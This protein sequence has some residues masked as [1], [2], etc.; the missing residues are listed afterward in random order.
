MSTLDQPRNNIQVSAEYLTFKAW[1]HE[2]L[3]ERTDELG[4][5]FAVMSKPAVRR[6][7]A[8][9][10][11]RLI[12]EIRIPLN[13]KEV[14]QLIDDLT[15]ELTGFGP[16]EGPLR[17]P[18]V[19]DIL[20]NGPYNIFI[21]K[22]GVIEPSDLV[23]IDEWHLMR[24]IYRLL[25]PTGRRVDESSPMVDARL[26][27]YGRINVVIPPLA[28]DGP[29][30]SIR[31]FPAD[32]L[33]AKDL[34]DHGT[35]TPEML[36][37]LQAAVQNRCNILISG[38]TSSGKTTLLNILASFARPQE[39]IVTIEDT[40]ELNLQARHIVRLET[41]PGGHDGAGAIDARDLLRNALR[42]RPDRIIVGEVRGSEAMEMLQ[43]MTTGHD[44][45]MGTLH[46]NSPREALQ[47]LEL[48]LSFAGFPGQEVTL[49]RQI[50]SA[51]EIIVQVARLADGR[52]RVLSITEV[53]GMGDN[54]VALQE[55][56]RYEP[57]TLP[58]GTLQDYW[59]NNGLRP[60]TRK[61]HHYQP[62]SQGLQ[63]WA[64]EEVSRG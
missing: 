17:D 61:L 54:I 47:R 42:M 49:R 39:R 18:E 4:H 35:L 20:V 52:R 59:I 28:L 16:L 23:F 3:V 31:R 29:T 48:L 34:I 11:D 1:A 50:A 33:K 36:E 25:L 43:A 41:R 8:L 38:G 44:G 6:F 51:L 2:K 13:E 64:H 27:L 14:E 7:V 63:N 15:N 30:L 10:M 46:A 53:T 37:F 19:E 26:P 5:D 56:F 62:R 32:P 21:G 55:H 24:I 58:D 45:S 57:R 22:K 40:A 9:E 12:Q 60:H